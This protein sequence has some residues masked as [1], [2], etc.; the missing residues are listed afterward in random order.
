MARRYLQTSVAPP[1]PAGGATSLATTTI[2][3]GLT[4]AVAPTTGQVLTALSA[5][6]ANWQTPSGGG[7]G[8][9]DDPTVRNGVFT[10]VAGKRYYLGSGFTFSVLLPA[11]PVDGD[12]VALFGVDVSAGV[13]TV[14]GNGA[15]LLSSPGSASGA[16]LNYDIRG[17][18]L[19]WRFTAGQWNQVSAA[20][21]SYQ[22]TVGTV[23][24]VP[25]G[26]AE[27]LQA[28]SSGALR[29]I[30]FDAGVP[31]A[32]TVPTGDTNDYG[33]LGSGR[34]QI[35]LF[36]FAGGNNGD[37]RITGFN[38][39]AMATA[40][41]FPP[42]Y[43]LFNTSSTNVVVLA[44]LNGGSAAANQIVSPTFCD[45]PL[46]PNAS[47]L[48][49]YDLAIT[50][51]VII[52]PA[53]ALYQRHETTSS[54]MHPFCRT[55]YTSAADSYTMPTPSINM[56]VG[57]ACV[58]AAPAS[59]FVLSPGFDIQNPITG[60]FASGSTGSMTPV[61]GTVWVFDGTQWLVE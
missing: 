26:T 47:V 12:V 14:D 25:L 48:I 2:P 31:P 28:M 38:A 1:A 8:V 34:F 37:N 19:W 23:I 29:K 4:S 55:T 59:V 61:R 16:T 42:I 54:P 60:T 43:M 27:P 52:G 24:G 50:S 5:V 21:T 13:V 36:P 41:D 33:V 57:I 18:D 30:A 17:L 20:V 51:W 53:P 56:R 15:T 58:A 6:A 3:V 7:G 32:F 49:W 45:Y 39:S 9:T 44:H 22:P 11:T 40:P 35:G 10:A 46:A